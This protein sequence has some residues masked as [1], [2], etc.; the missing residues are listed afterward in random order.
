MWPIDVPGQDERVT[1][2]CLLLAASYRSLTRPWRRP[3]NNHAMLTIEYLYNEADG[4]STQHLSGLLQLSTSAAQGKP[5]D[6][7]QI[8]LDSLGR[9]ANKFAYG[10]EIA[11]GY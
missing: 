7:P 2:D 5:K 8:A 3:T 6:S 4:R 9:F 11:V 1:N 10:P